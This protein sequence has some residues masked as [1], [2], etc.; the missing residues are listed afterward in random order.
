MKV[1]VLVS[2]CDTELGN[3]G[4]YTTY[5]KA[6][7]AMEAEYQEWVKNGSNE[8]YICEMGANVFSKSGVYVEWEIA[9][10]E[11]E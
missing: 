9:T 1:Y 3:P 4:V 8:N 6:Y 2:R 10:C 11:V 7:R 5:D